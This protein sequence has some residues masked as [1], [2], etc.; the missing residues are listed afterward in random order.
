MKSMGGERVEAGATSARGLHADRM[1]AV[2]DIALGAITNAR[3]LPPLLK[4]TARYPEDPAEFL[5]EPG[6]ALEVVITLPSGEDVSSQDDRVHALL[7]ELVGRDVRL[8]ALPQLSEKARHRAPRENKAD[9]R[10]H[11]G[12]AE[13]EP[14][15]DLSMFPLRKLAQLSRYVTPLGSYVD[16]YPLHLITYT[17][18]AAM[19]EHTPTADFNVRRFRPNLVLDTDE[20]DRLPETQWC[21]A[22]L[23][24]PG[25]TLRGEI[26][27]VRCVMPT[28][29]QTDLNADPDVLRT[30]AAHAERCLG[31]YA[32]V[33]RA[34][35]ISVRDEVHVRHPHT[36]PRPVAVARSGAATLKRGL[37]RA[38]NALMPADDASR[39]RKTAA[40]T[41]TAR[42]SRTTEFSTAELMLREA[43]CSSGSPPRPV[44]SELVSVGTNRPEGERDERRH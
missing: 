13:N 18:I 41:V 17:S 43:R 22:E 30:V 15:P 10:A 4:C 24:T 8:E 9:M 12:L 33:E 27:T 32:T 31:L 38:A 7:S 37:L 6:N 25:V 3:R 26:P 14:M 16:A 44:A 2:R 40:R 5:A 1:W 23:E 11:F 42:P 29:E 34:G 21:G 36:P 35:V 19:A 39:H 28:R 20:A